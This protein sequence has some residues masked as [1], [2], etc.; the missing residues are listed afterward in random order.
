MAEFS[1]SI[2]VKFSI[3]FISSFNTVDII[4][5]SMKNDNNVVKVT[6]VVTVTIIIDEIENISFEAKDVT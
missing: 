5:L 4:D 2:V 1:G 6:N 3:L